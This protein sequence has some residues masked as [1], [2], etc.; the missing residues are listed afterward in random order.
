MVELLDHRVIFCS[1]FLDNAKL[2]SKEMYHLNAD[3]YCQMF[4]FCQS[5]EC[6]MVFHGGFNL[7]FPDY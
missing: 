5:G 7:Y 3:P 2:S 4:T 1:A 6:I